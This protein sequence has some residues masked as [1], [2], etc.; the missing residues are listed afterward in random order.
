MVVVETSIFTRLICSLL[1]DEEIR[2]LQLALVLRPDQ[3]A[4]IRGAGG[5]RK[6]RWNQPGRGKRG[7]L[8]VLYYWDR[9][10]DRLY[11]IYLFEKTRQ[12]DLTAAQIK[13]LGRVVREELK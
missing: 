3:G 5:L 12:D 10:A 11:M 6:V 1:P 9:A 2:R 8:R 4:V 7:S 13:T